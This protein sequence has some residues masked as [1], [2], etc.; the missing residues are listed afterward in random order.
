MLLWHTNKIS[1]TDSGCFSV[2]FWLAIFAAKK[3]PKI[4]CGFCSLSNS[5]FF[6]LQVFWLQSS[7]ILHFHHWNCIVCKC[8][9][10]FAGETAKLLKALVV[11]ANFVVLLK[12]I[13]VALLFIQWING[14]IMFLQQAH[15]AFQMTCCKHFISVPISFLTWQLS[16]F[17]NFQLAMKLQSILNF[18]KPIEISN[19]NVFPF[20]TN[21]NGHFRDINFSWQIAWEV[22]WNAHHAVFDEWI[23]FVTFHKL[24]QGKWN[25]INQCIIFNFL[26]ILMLFSNNSTLTSFFSISGLHAAIDAKMINNVNHANWLK[27][28]MQHWFGLALGKQISRN[29]FE[30]WKN[31]ILAAERMKFEK[32]CQKHLWIQ[33]M[34]WTNLCSSQGWSAQWKTSKLQQRRHIHKKIEII[35]LPLWMI[36][37]R[38]DCLL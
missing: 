3:F 18:C 13:L 16:L 25:H 15:L 38:M 12:T 5:T 8:L 28:K 11:I 31:D 1:K 20:F 26:C 19:A 9:D 2:T 23:W 17:D 32:S 14:T 4:C 27:L 21:F 34:L 37:L 30:F 10:S 6:F 33:K 36:L 22:F 29:K 7:C 35:W 24:I